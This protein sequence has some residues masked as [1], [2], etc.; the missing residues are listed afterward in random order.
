MLQIVLFLRQVIRHNPV[1]KWRC[2]CRLSL[3]H[4]TQLLLLLDGGLLGR[5]DPSFLRAIG[6]SRVAIILQLIPILRSSPSYLLLEGA[7]LV[8][9]DAR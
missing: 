7:S 8:P 3:V 2:A 6:Q 1:R 5:Y 9:L 4:N